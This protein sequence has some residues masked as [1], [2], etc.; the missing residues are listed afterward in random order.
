VAVIALNPAA[1][2]SPEQLRYARWL[3]AGTRIGLV[4]L[5]ASFALYVT[6][7]LP[8]KVAPHELPQLWSLPVGDYLRATDTA[9]GWAWLGQLA[10]GD[11][12]ALLGIA[13]LAACSMPCL[14]ALLP[15]LRHDRR[16]AL[17]CMAEVLVIAAAASGLIAGRH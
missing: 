13:W 7:V 12:Q 6:G 2:Q 4:L 5:A 16:F 11:R 1:A 14:L 8:S 9:T 3:D 15:L 10:H 17:L